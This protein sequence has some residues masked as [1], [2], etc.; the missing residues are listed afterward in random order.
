MATLLTM[1]ECLEIFKKYDKE[2]Y[3]FYSKNAYYFGCDARNYAKYLKDLHEPSE[4]V[5]VVCLTTAGYIGSVTVTSKEYAASTAR[6]LRS[7]GCKVRCMD[8]EKFLE[9]QEKEAKERMPHFYGGV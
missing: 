9:L 2:R 5:Y 1:D 8:R 6:Q 4:D 7:G 3:D